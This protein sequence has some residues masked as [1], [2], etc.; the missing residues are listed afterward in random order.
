MIRAALA[1][2][3]LLL[4]R[5]ELRT[6]KSCHSARSRASP[7]TTRSVGRRHRSRANERISCGT[8]SAHREGHPVATPVAE[9]ETVAEVVVGGVIVGVGSTGVGVGVGVGVGSTG[10]GV[11]VGVGVGSTGVGVG[12]GTSGV[13][14]GSTGVVFAIESVIGV[15]RAVESLSSE[16]FTCGV[17]FVGGLTGVGFVGVWAVAIAGNNAK[18]AAAP[19]IRS[20]IFPPVSYA[21]GNPLRFTV[22]NGG[23]RTQKRQPARWQTGIKIGVCR[24]K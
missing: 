24:G 4:K 2:S 19:S 21:N 15:G 5:E 9:L 10:V 20:F 12:V 7:R 6:G 23:P 3:Q 16:S 22:A 14:V 18:P 11:G 17:G 13:V 8:V 1:I